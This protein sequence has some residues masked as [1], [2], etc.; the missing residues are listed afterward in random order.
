MREIGFVPQEAVEALEDPLPAETAT[1][2]PDP[3]P[4]TRV[5][6]RRE[7]DKVWAKFFPRRQDPHFSPSTAS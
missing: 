7:S 3:D 4:Y 2:E 6:K 1:D 5:E